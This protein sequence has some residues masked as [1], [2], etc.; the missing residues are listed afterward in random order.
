MRDLTFQSPVIPTFIQ[1]PATSASILSG[2]LV[3][4]PGAGSSS[5]ATKSVKRWFALLPDFVLYTFRTESDERALTATP[6]PGYSVLTGTQ[7][8]GDASVPDK[9]RDKIIKMFVPAPVAA[10]TEQMIQSQFRKV[11][12]FAG[13]SVEEVERYLRCCSCSA[14]CCPP[15]SSRVFCPS[16]YKGFHYTCDFCV[17]FPCRTG[18]RLA[19]QS[20]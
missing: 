14:L 7:L 6:L 15:P 5:R 11:Y 20:N 3:L 2:F 18:G 16:F 10:A 1:V 12:Y 17:R 9:D 8:K 13:T 19:G 4:K